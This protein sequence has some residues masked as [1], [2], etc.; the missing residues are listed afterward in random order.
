MCLFQFLRVP[1][2]RVG[3]YLLRFERG[4]HSPQ[5]ARESVAWSE[6]EN[7]VD[8]WLFVQLVDWV[9]GKRG[10]E[11]EDYRI[12]DLSIV[13]DELAGKK[14]VRRVIACMEPLVKLETLPNL[15]HGGSPSSVQH[16]L[17]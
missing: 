4:L 3:V 12:L 13:L 11:P 16:Y 9:R 14:M 1:V 8:N 10:V 6:T 7:M 5:D 15:D 17:G 2:E